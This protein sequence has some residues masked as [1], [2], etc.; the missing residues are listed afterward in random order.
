LLVAVAVLFAITWAYWSTLLLLAERWS[1]DPQYS[2]GWLVP[3]FSAY[4]I[5]SRRNAFL[6]VPNHQ[7]WWGIA[8]GVFGTAARALAYWLYLPWLESISL[9][10]F[11][12]GLASVLGGWRMLRAAI[13]SILFLLFMLPLPYRLQQ[14]LGGSLQSVATQASTYLLQTIGVPAISEGNIILLTT[15]RIGV[16]EACNGLSMLMTF[17]ALAV[18]LALVI[19]R[20]WLYTLT[21]VIAAVPIA[22]GANIIR[23]AV[24]G[25]LF[26]S[27]HN[28]E[29]HA[30]YH[31]FSGW[32]MMPLGALMLLALLWTMDR[33][34]RRHPSP[35]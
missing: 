12:A 34:V 13:P 24:T 10:F 26:E 4:L 6:S 14:T 15:E 25:L 32:A 29:A 16:V 23:I 2:H 27:S 20:H 17:L 21:L 22:I 28:T 30:F 33:S 5:Y 35:T 9:L 19:D 11:L 18:G 31:D 8:F 7:Y 3:L 1:K